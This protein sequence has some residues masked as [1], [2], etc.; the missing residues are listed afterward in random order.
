MGRA[1]RAFL[2]AVFRSRKPS[3]L[4]SKMNL[5]TLIL[6]GGDDELSSI[7]RRL[8]LSVTSAW[9]KGDAKRR[10]GVRAD[11]GWSAT[12]AD[13]QSPAALVSAVRAFLA[14]CQEQ[15]VN[16]LAP[17][18]KAQIAIGITVGDAEQFVACIDFTAD[19]LVA[20]GALG[21]KLSVWAYPTSDEANE[22]MH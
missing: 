6:S 12:I 13:M 11:S 10:G 5:A 14:T 1:T 21:L 2:L 18:L 9:K 19:D 4:P 8:G 22:G 15:N 3:D 20:L 17:S 16:F 7:C